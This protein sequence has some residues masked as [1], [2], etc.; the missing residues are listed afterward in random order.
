MVE[1]LLREKVVTTNHARAHFEVLEALFM[2][3]LELLLADTLKFEGFG[4]GVVDDE[5]FL[6]EFQGRL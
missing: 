3:G 6:K 1:V 2:R 4:M 5:D